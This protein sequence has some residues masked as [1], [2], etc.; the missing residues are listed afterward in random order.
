MHDV[1]I[2]YSSVNKTVA[3]NICHELEAN[4]IRCWYAPRDIKPSESWASAIMAAIRQARVF[5]LIYS[6]DSNSSVQ[7]LNEVTNA[8]NEECIIIPFRLDETSMSDQLAYY[9]NAVHW[10]DATSNSLQTSIATLRDT[11]NA[12]LTS[13]QPVP[14]TKPVTPKK[15]KMNGRAKRTIGIFF[16]VLLLA[17][18]ALCF[19]LQIPQKIYFFCISHIGYYTYPGT[20]HNMMASD[21][22]SI[23]LQEK[24]TD[25]FQARKVAAPYEALWDMAYSPEHPTDTT[26]HINSDNDYV[27]IKD[28]RANLLSI[29]NRKTE[30]WVLEDQPLPTLSDT[31][32]YERY[33]YC[34]PSMLTDRNVTNAVI[35]LIFDTAPDA[36]CYTKLITIFDDGAT[37][38]TDISE[39]DLSKL[40]C[41]MNTQDGIYSA[42]MLNRSTRPVLLD[43]QT[44]EIITSD[45]KLIFEEHISY[46]N[47]HNDVLSQDKRYILDT[48]YSEDGSSEVMV[49]DLKTGLPAFRETFPNGCEI[50]FSGE[51]TLMYFD[52][53]TCSV[54]RVDLEGNGV[55]TQLIDAKKLDKSRHFLDYVYYFY[56]SDI[57][58]LCFFITNEPK[59]IGK[60]EKFLVTVTDTKGKVVAKSDTIEVA[61]A[62][63]FPSIRIT[64]ESVLMFL[65]SLDPEK[66]LSFEE[67]TVIYRAL[68]TVDADGKLSFTQSYH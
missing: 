1:F 17:A 28:L 63:V 32:I 21:G 66:P 44:G 6:K 15:R 41:T 53:S 42:L 62:S 5:V 31:E 49:W 13:Q 27:Y 38:V 24:D 18:A 55:K 56:Y 50:C 58:D 51:H 23:L 61:H 20:F 45:H 14:P 46:A 60:E 30:E 39:L 54:F 40:I 2:S 11:V 7:V 52:Y 9:L 19:Y 57:Y 48:Q 3:D 67:L 33:I 25:N 36:Q 12:V 59:A 16:L 22:N 37:H 35:E 68:Y 65:T 29:Y 4:N 26:A 43:L 47:V 64:D 10:L 34:S 8:C